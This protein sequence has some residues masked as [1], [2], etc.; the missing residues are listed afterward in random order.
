MNLNMY[1]FDGQQDKY[2]VEEWASKDIFALA[3]RFSDGTFRVDYSSKNPKPS[4]K[5]LENLLANSGEEKHL[6]VSGFKDYK[7]IDGTPILF[8]RDKTDETEATQ[9]YETLVIKTGIENQKGLIVYALKDADYVHQG[10]TKFITHHKEKG[11]LEIQA[12]QNPKDKDPRFYWVTSVTIPQD[13]FLKHNVYD[14]WS[15]AEGETTN[16]K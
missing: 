1:R 11:H 5:F 7:V 14:I 4:S 2:M 13:P 10:K 12:R 9:I 16:E 15:Q 3:T 8:G 6:R